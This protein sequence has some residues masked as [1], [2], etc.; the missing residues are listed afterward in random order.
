[1]YKKDQ[2]MYN[3]YTTSLHTFSDRTHYRKGDYR[4]YYSSFGALA[5][6]LHFIINARMFGN[7][8]DKKAS[9]SAYRY[10]LFLISLS[11]Y[12]ATDILW[13]ILYDTRIVALVYADTFLYFLSMV[14]SVLLWTRFVVSYLDRKGLFGSFLTYAGWTIFIFQLLN[15][16]VNFFYPIVFHFADNGDYFPSYSR[17]ISLAMQVIL[18]IISAVYSII[19]AV[20]AKEKERIH[21]VTVGFSGIVMTIFIVL[22]TLYPFLPFYAVGAI[23]GTS[24]IHIF[25]EEDER[26][27]FEAEM[28]EIRENAERFRLESEKTKKKTV[29]FGQIAESLVENYDIVYYVDTTDEDYVGYIS[30]SLRGRLEADRKGESFFEVATDYMDRL[31]YPGDRE[32]MVGLLDKDYLLTA[33]RSRKQFNVDCR[34]KVGD[35]YEYTRFSVRKTSDSRHFLIVVENV[36]DEVRREKAQQKALSN[37]KALARRDE[38]T[39]TKNKTAYIE[40]EQSVQENIDKGLDYLPFALAVCDIN[41]LKEINDT[42]GHQAGDDYIRTAA[43]LLCDIFVHSPVFRIGGD[44]FLVFL[45]GDDY[46]AKEELVNRLRAKVFQNS[47]Q[48]SGP[49]V[50]IGVTAYDPNR[51][52]SVSQ[53]FERADALMY[54]NKKELKSL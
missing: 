42:E 24:L 46:T 20:K 16:I 2:M 34:I 10:K 39:G 14:L 30:N 3:D 27:D 48:K 6:I 5:I 41:D 32:R 26:N 47:V 52:T 40:L 23:I 1:M 43:K 19:V 15:L 38:L 25:V 53:V 17:Y 7:K 31:C 36:D 29:T 33:L 44:E 4:M 18:F 45:R 11:F 13:G 9:L 12:Y 51:D 21:Y 50:A 22:Q 28:G 49:V 35:D 37:E 8:W 54:E